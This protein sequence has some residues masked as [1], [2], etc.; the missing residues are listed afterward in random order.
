LTWTQGSGFDHNLID[1]GESSPLKNLSPILLTDGLFPASEVLKIFVADS[2]V[3]EQ[4][5]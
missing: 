4:Q 5:N 3:I 1:D 2:E